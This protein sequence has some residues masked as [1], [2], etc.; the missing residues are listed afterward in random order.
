[1]SLSD[2]ES[3]EDV[4][5]SGSATSFNEVVSGRTAVASTVVLLIV[6]GVSALSELLTVGAVVDVVEVVAGVAAR[7]SSQGGS[8]LGVVCALATGR[9]V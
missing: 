8:G 5:P 4:T 7:S 9:H 3:S 2:R 1:M 6:V